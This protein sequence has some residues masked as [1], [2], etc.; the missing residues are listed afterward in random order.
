MYW[1]CFFKLV[2]DANF[3]GIFF[4][5][6]MF[7]KKMVERFTFVGVTI[8]TSCNSDSCNKTADKR[9]NCRNMQPVICMVT[10]D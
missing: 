3:P 8:L 10:G 2:V 6:N 4:V 1:L 5:K 9:N 7:G